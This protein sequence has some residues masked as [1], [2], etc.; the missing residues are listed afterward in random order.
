[1]EDQ[2]GGLRAGIGGRETGEVNL[3]ERV[4]FKWRV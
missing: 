2:E 4:V 1:M 3:T